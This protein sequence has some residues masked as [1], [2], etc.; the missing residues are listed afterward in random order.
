VSPDWNEV[1][2]LAQAGSVVAL[3]VSLI[4]VLRQLQSQGKDQFVSGTASTFSVWSSDDFQAAVQWVLYE[5]EATTWRAFVKK[6][7]NKYGERAFIRV[8]SYFNRVGYLVN[9]DLLGGLEPLMI[10]TVA[11][12]AIAVW[13]KVEP[14]VLEARLV[15]NARLFQDFETMLPA[16][17]DCYVPQQPWLPGTPDPP[18][19][20]ADEQE[21]SARQRH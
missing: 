6:Y 21:G 3:V 15:E 13:R 5:L 1:A 9:R 2:A 11:P 8:G 12:S 16:C 7:R 10:E 14:L 4:L 17:F 18:A 19:D 20:L